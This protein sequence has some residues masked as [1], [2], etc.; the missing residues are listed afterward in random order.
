MRLVTHEPGFPLAKFVGTFWDCTDAPPHS[1][2]RILPSGTIELV[3]NLRED[4]IRIYDAGQPDR[5]ERFP[6]I[7]VSGTYARAFVIDP[8]QHASMM[9]IHFRPGGAYPFLG[10]NL[11]ELANRHLALQS[12][13]GRP[14]VALRER[15]CHA[16]T[17]QQRFKIL[18]ETLD[19]QVRLSPEHPAVALA[20]DIFGP[21]GVGE[22][23][24]AVSK[25]VGLSQRRF[26]QVFKD[27]VGL[28]PKLFCR[29]LRFQHART[30]MDETATLSCAQLAF[31]C[32]YY[33]QSHLIRDFQEFSG[34]SPTNYLR[35]RC[36]R[37]M[38]NHVPLIG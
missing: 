5:C 2:E 6:G 12:V 23:V 26:I 7:V 4:E 29:V 35:L 14:A 36:N 38:R 17:P 20:L 10:G 31:S 9:G 11:A 19:A 32:G 21:L 28:P 16:A 27:Y 30:V 18:E 22:T 24:R 37:L 3:I 1:R 25:V 13:W 8:T 15:L 34:L 33:D